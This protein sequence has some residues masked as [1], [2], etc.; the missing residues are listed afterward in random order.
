[1]RFVSRLAPRARVFRPDIAG[2]SRN[3]D[4][5]AA[6]A[7]DPLIDP[8][9]IAART[10]AELLE[11]MGIIHARARGV[12]LPLL[13]LHGTADRVTDP[14]GSEAFLREVVSSRKRY[15]PVPGAYHDLFHEPEAPQL[16]ATFAD[17]LDLD[18]PST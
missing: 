12:T 7:R 4:V 1:V 3:P 2:F 9:P 10:V 5:L 14:R 17:W 18:A 8:R 13:V 6:M 16:R 15:V 11:S